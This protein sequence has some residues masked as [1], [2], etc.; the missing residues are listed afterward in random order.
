MLVSS[1]FLWCRSAESDVVGKAQP[2]SVSLNR[3]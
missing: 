2:F 1:S 3:Q